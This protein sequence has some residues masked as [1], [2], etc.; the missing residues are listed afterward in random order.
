MWTVCTAKILE[1]QVVVIA[2]YVI[3]NSLIL[4]H[5]ISRIYAHLLRLFINMYV[6]WAL[7]HRHLEAVLLLISLIGSPVSSP[8]TN[9]GYV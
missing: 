4:V 3:V 1:I 2:L 7:Q 8:T 9:R 6:V 5:E